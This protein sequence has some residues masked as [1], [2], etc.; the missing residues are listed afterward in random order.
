VSRDGKK[1]GDHPWPLGFPVEYRQWDGVVTADLVATPA[2]EWT[3]MPRQ[4]VVLAAYRQRESAMVVPVEGVGQGV[5]SF[6]QSVGAGCSWFVAGRPPIAVAMGCFAVARADQA[7]R[8]V[9]QWRATRLQVVALAGYQ[10]RQS[11]T[12][13]VVAVSDHQV[14]NFVPGTG[15]ACWSSVEDRPPTDVARA[16]FVV[17]EGQGV[18]R[19]EE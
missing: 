2:E 14:A 7:A 1:T 11:G 13:R 17:A 10:R 18:A 4:V 8:P 9:E 15:G 19:T 12:E 6:G 16:I 3:T 5:A